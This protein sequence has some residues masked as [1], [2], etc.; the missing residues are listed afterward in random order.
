MKFK[1]TLIA[2]IVASTFA[3]AVFAADSAAAAKEAACCA[4]ATKD[5]KACG[6]ECCAAAAKDGKNCA[7]CGGSGAVAKK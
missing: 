3:G 5:G 1:N 4:K 7:A 6:H 2:L